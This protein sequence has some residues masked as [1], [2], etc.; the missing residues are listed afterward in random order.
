MV[1][2]QILYL[3]GLV[4]VLAQKHFKLGIDPILITEEPLFCLRSLCNGMQK[5][6]IHEFVN[7]LS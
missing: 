7:Q 3:K 4:S 5:L 2:L 1:C 6:E